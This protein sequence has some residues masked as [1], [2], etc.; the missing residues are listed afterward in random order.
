MLKQL[1]KLWILRDL[2]WFE[3][4]FV[5]INLE[6]YK[7]RIKYCLDEKLIISFKMFNEILI[8][9]LVNIIHFVTGNSQP[10]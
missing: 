9:E 7:D 1:F 3:W 2:F 8:C 6:D 5:K 10:C 4:I